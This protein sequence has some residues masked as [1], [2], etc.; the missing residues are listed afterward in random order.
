[1]FIFQTMLFQQPANM[2]LLGVLNRSVHDS[3]VGCF[4][5]V[6]INFADMNH[7]VVL[8]HNIR[9]FPESHLPPR[10]RSVIMPRNR[11]HIGVNSAGL[12]KV[13]DQPMRLLSTNSERRCSSR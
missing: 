12:T 7:S 11:V 3:P 4:G 9:C 2:V 13:L 6:S 1:V 8:N 5:L 10:G